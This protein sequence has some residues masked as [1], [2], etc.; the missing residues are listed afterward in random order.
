L[1]KDEQ[2]LKFIYFPNHFEGEKDMPLA[3]RRSWIAEL[4]D[5]AFN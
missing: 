1:A 5:V 4:P 2:Y 3:A